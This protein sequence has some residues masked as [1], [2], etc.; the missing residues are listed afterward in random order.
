MRAPAAVVAPPSPVAIMSSSDVA[1]QG[2]FGESSILI[3]SPS[4]ACTPCLLLLVVV[5]SQRVTNFAL[6]SIKRRIY[7]VMRHGAER[8]GAAAL[9]SNLSKALRAVQPQGK[10]LS[11]RHACRSSKEGFA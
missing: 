6:R 5:V 8:E 4:V 11:T 1:E 7:F 3:D 9:R 10:G 2:Y